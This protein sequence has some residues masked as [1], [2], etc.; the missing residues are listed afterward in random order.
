MDPARMPEFLITITHEIKVDQVGCLIHFARSVLLDKN[1]A[2]RV[3]PIQLRHPVRNRSTGVCYTHSR[4]GIGCNDDVRLP[5]DCNQARA[6]VSIR[7]DKIESKLLNCHID[8]LI[9]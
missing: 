8:K 9:K 5:I 3:D 7:G 1:H 4:V 2:L 6:W